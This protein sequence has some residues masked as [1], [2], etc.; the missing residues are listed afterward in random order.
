MQGNFT[1]VNRRM[2]KMTGYAVETLL[3]FPFIEL[4]PPTEASNIQQQLLAIANNGISIDEYY[5]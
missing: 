5:T 4:F 2:A 3:G 1:L